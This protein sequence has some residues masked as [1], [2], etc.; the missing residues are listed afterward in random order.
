MRKSSKREG[1]K[2][3]WKIALEG[4]PNQTLY[5]RPCRLVYDWRVA[6]RR[7]GETSRRPWPQ[8][9]SLR[10]LVCRHDTVSM[11]TKEIMNDCHWNVIFVKSVCIVRNS[12]L[13]PPIRRRLRTEQHLH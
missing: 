3:R 1:R 7:M 6:T 10:L 11:L 4:A 12:T 9:M 5:L 2:L 13:E 8:K